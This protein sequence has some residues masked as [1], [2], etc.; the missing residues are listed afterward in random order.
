MCNIE[1]PLLYGTSPSSNITMPSLF[2]STLIWHG[3]ALATIP[4][5]SVFVAIF[6][7]TAMDGWFG[8]V[9][10]S[11][12]RSLL[13]ECEPFELVPISLLREFVSSP[14]RE[15][16]EIVQ[17]C[18]RF[19]HLLSLTK[20]W[21]WSEHVARLSTLL[22]CGLWCLW[23]DTMVNIVVSMSIIDVKNHGLWIIW[24]R[25]HFGNSWCGCSCKKKISNNGA[26][27]NLTR[28]AMG[29]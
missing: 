3:A 5:P 14:S 23:P 13:G 27:E 24:W 16:L 28:V 1:T 29:T 15:T 21:P 20:R 22:R 8:S 7:C 17:S 19:A 9:V 6:F 26:A 12:S 10:Y 2:V 25:N 4:S 18:G 11:G